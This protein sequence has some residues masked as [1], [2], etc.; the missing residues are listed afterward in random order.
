MNVTIRYSSVQPV[1]IV[2]FAILVLSTLSAHHASRVK[3]ARK[4]KKEKTLSDPFIYNHSGVDLTLLSVP[5]GE[6]K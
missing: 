2:Y 6:L 3:V 5:A 1:S 4:K